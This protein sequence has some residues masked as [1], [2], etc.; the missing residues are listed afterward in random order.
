MQSFDN[1]IINIIEKDPRYPFNAY[2]FLREAL[3]YTIKSLY[4]ENTVSGHDSHIP[5]Q[6][7]LVGIRDFALLQYGPLAFT[8][9]DHWN[10]KTTEDFGNI[11]F[12][13]V[14]QGILTKTKEDSIEDF[15][16]GFDFYEAFQ[17]PFLPKTASGKKTK[18]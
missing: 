1:I 18:K 5:G 11:V 2:V 3:E 14:D 13:L 15:K 16:K 7:L 10:I 4:P 9:L 12:N 6:K 17:K 8:V